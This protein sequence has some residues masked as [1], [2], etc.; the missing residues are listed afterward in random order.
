MDFECSAPYKPGQ[1]K[2]T[3]GVS[4]LCI[5]M[6]DSEEVKNPPSWKGFIF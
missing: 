3:Q 2:W 1:T 6:Q 4:D 5:H